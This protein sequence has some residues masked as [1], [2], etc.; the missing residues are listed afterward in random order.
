MVAGSNGRFLSIAAIGADRSELPLPPFI[1]RGSAPEMHA[2]AGSLAMSTSFM[3]T[4]SHR[5]FHFSR[6]RVS[7]L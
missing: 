5:E 3:P 7:A 1:E 6:D 2:W 4:F